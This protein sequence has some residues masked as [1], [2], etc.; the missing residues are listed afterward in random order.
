M[1]KNKLSVCLMNLSKMY[2]VFSDAKR[3]NLTS[4]LSACD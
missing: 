4:L 3:N 1:V 2:C